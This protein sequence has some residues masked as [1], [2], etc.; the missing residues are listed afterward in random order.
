[1]II[2]THLLLLFPDPS[3]PHHAKFMS[4]KKIIR[5]YHSL[6]A[7]G[8]WVWVLGPAST[9]CARLCWLPR[10]GLMFSEE[11]IREGWGRWERERREVG[12]GTVVG[13]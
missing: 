6:D 2:F 11:W 10:G 12:G 13:K 1:M 9:E 8:G 5:M 7:A 3:S 4:F